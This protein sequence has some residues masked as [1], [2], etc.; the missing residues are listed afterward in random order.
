MHVFVLLLTGASPLNTGVTNTCS[1]CAGIQHL[2]GKSSFL[3]WFEGLYPKYFDET[4]SLTTICTFVE[5]S[6]K[7]IP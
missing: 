4:L 3:E 6:A 2:T 7:Y 1:A 5:H